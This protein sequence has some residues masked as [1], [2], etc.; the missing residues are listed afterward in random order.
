MEKIL[1]FTGLLL[2]PINVT[3]SQEGYE[4]GPPPVQT[5]L[6][7]KP[8]PR[9]T[10]PPRPQPLEAVGVGISKPQPSSSGHSHTDSSDPL[11]WLRESVPGE[12]GLDY[13]IYASPPST[14]FS[15]VGR[16]PGLYAD[17]EAGCQAWHT[18]L[19]TRSWTHLCPNGTIFNQGIFSCVWWFEFD[20]EEAEQLYSLNDN[21]YK[22]EDSKNRGPDTGVGSRD[23]GFIGVVRQSTSQGGIKGQDTRGVSNGNFGGGKSNNGKPNIGRPSGGNISVRPTGG[24]P[25]G[26]S[27]SATP[28]GGKLF[29]V[30]NSEW[31]SGGRPSG[32]KPSGKN[33]KGKHSRGRLSV[34]GQSDAVENVVKPSGRGHSKARPGGENSVDGNRSKDRKRGGQRTSGARFSKGRPNTSHPSKGTQGGQRLNK[35]QPSSG[36]PRGQGISKRPNVVDGLVLVLPAVDELP[37]YRPDTGYG[38]PGRR[39]GREEENFGRLF[40]Y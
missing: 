7:L 36:R 25:S 5:Q 29:G 35:G 20:C 32:E 26:G 15:C 31:P 40:D 2:F 24:R 34:R 6:T 16:E 10:R 21:L 12:P 14:V 11:A 39:G 33:S 28:S 17:I 22:S 27:N 13:P 38:A 3:N 30:N 23:Q 8:K 1:L 37:S 18:C 9:P 4:Y 19:D